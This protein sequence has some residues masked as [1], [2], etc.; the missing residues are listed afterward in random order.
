FD[1]KYAALEAKASDAAGG[2]RASYESRIAALTASFE[3]REKDWI[4]ERER[5]G[6]ELATVSNSVQSLAAERVEKIKSAYEARKAELEEQFEEKLAAATSALAFEKAQMIADLKTA[7]EQYTRLSEQF[8]ELENTI[9]AD[10]R[11]HHE[12]IMGKLAEK[13]AAL[14]EQAERFGKELA[15]KDEFAAGAALDASA[16]ES[17]WLE[18]K[19]RLSADFADRLS[20][21][22]AGLAKREEALENQYR[23]KSA[24]LEKNAAEV[25]ALM[26]ADFNRR[27]EVEKQA[28]EAAKARLSDENRLKGEQLSEARAMASER[29][30]KIRALYETRKAELE[31]QLEE[32]MAAASAAMASEKARLLADLR[33]AG[34]EY[35]GLSE[36]F[37]ELENAIASDRRM[38]HE[39]LMRHMAAK[40]AALNQQAGDFEKEISKLREDMEAREAAWL[41]EREKMRAAVA[42]AA[43][44]YEREAAERVSAI[45]VEHEKKRAELERILNERLAEKEAVLRL[46]MGK[47]LEASRLK[48][49]RIGEAHERIKDLEGR[50]G[51]LGEAHRRELAERLA[52]KE[53]ALKAQADALRGE[54]EAALERQ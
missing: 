49:G 3:K 25:R 28:F 23:L 33:T 45:E 1:D 44:R 17:A 13:E 6:G 40:E 41:E 2:D 12:E 50:L 53:S 19:K 36:R 37:K 5:L 8:K 20:L 15:L 54:K 26:E 24:E 21:Q 42:E 29:V 4:L 43:V 34:E 35:S 46:E 52:E 22:E 10:R 16:K 47:I 32:R 48:D 27:V 14:K 7:S 11:A 51:A 39:E 31:K 18:E 38:H 9:A 30:E